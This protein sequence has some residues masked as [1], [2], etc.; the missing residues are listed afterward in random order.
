MDDKRSYFDNF[1]EKVRS[2]T[3]YRSF[4]ES[5]SPKPL[6]GS[7]K[8]LDNHLQSNSRTQPFTQAVGLINH[9]LGSWGDTNLPPSKAK[10]YMD[11]TRQV[12]QRKFSNSYAF[13]NSSFNW[14]KEGNPTGAVMNFLGGMLAGGYD[15]AQEKR[16]RYGFK[17]QW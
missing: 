16:E 14:A 7:R 9:N 2:T 11:L 15:A 10:N 6:Q 17:K 12:E 13:L 8:D 1:A 3:I 5:P 4:A